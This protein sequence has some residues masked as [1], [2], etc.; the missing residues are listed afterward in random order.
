MDRKEELR[1]QDLSYVWHPETLRKDIVKWGA[2]IIA[3]GEGYKLKDIDGKEYI[4]ALGGM[5]CTNVGHG[6]KEIID[7]MAE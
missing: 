7:A 4:D 3:E 2:K 1:Q 5:E 6:R